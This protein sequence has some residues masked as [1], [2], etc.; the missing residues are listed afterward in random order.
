MKLKK[1]EFFI[2]MNSQINNHFKL[3]LMKLSDYKEFK[4]SR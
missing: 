4:I 3:N 1:P 2:K